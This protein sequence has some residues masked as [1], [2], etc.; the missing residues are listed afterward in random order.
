MK[1]LICGD[2]FA[3][4]WSEKHKEYYG[5]P[6][7]MKAHFDITNVAQCG[8]G[9]YKVLKQIETVGDLSKFDLILIS[10]CSPWRL[11]TIR[12]PVHYDDVLHK[13]S[14]LIFSD[15]EYHMKHSKQTDEL[16]AAF[17][18]YIHHYDKEYHS[19]T[20]QLYRKEINNKINTRPSY[21]LNFR[22]SEWATESN[23]IHFTDLVESSPGAI[24]HISEQGNKTVA[25][26]ILK[27]IELEFNI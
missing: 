15:I 20:Y 6:T 17:E 26:S 5:W 9:P 4:D 23:I 14:D 8:V 1:I 7:L 24:N 27:K 10:H 12:N 3:A 21:I 16:R 22:K 25:N 18:F 2:S 13:D 19:K 11:S